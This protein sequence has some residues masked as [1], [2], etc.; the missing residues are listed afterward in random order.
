MGYGALHRHIFILAFTACCSLYIHCAEAQLYQKIELLKR[1]DGLSDDRVTCVYKDRTGYLWI[2]TEGGLNRYDGHSFTIFKP[3]AGNSISNEVINAITEDAS[4]KIWVAT[5]N[6]LNSYTPQ[7]KRWTAYLANGKN[8]SKTLP[9]PIVWSCFVDKD[10]RIWITTDRHGPSVLAADRS[11]FTHYPWQQFVNAAKPALKGQYFTAVKMIPAGDIIYLGS[12]IGLFTNNKLNGQFKWLGEANGNDILDMQYNSGSQKLYM[13]TRS[14]EVFFYNVATNHF[15]KLKPASLHFPSTHFWSVMDS[16]LRIGYTKGLLLA[17]VDTDELLLQQHQ[18]GI[19]ASLPSAGVQT[20]YSDNTGI[21]WIGTNDGLAKYDPHTQQANFLPLIKPEKNIA[22]NPMGAV[23]YDTTTDA[24]FVCSIETGEVFIISRGL[25]TIISRKYDAAGKRFN[26]CLAIRSDRQNGLWLLTANH[27]YKFNRQRLQFELFPTPNHENE[28]VFRDMAQDE[29]GNFW[30]AGF[31]SPLYF[32]DSKKKSFGVPGDTSIFR[33][34]SKV[35]SILYDSV[36]KFLWIGTFSNGL[37]RYD[38]R[39]KK[40]TVFAESVIAPHYAFF[41]LINNIYQDKNGR[42]WIATHAGGLFYYIPHQSFEHSFKQISMKDGLATNNMHSIT[43]NRSF[44]WAMSGKS[45]SVLESNTAKYLHELGEDKLLP[46]SSFISDEQNPHYIDFDHQR[47]ELLIA[48]GGGLMICK[49]I[50]AKSRADFPVIISAISVNNKP[51]LTGNS[52][53]TASIAF[54]YP[55]RELNIR[56][57]ALHYSASAA[58]RFRYKLTGYDDTWKTAV[59]TNELNFQNLPPG[60]Y[61]FQLGATDY[62]GNLSSSQAI[63]SFEVVPPF[64]K[65][66]LFYALVS[67]LAVLILVILFKQFRRKIQMEQKLNKFATSLYG[68]NTIDAVLREVAVACVEEFQFSGC[69]ILQWNPASKNYELLYSKGQTISVPQPDHIGRKSILQGTMLFELPILV[70]N[71]AIAQI[72]A[73]K[74]DSIWDNRLYKKTLQKAARV[75]SQKID[76]YIVE[77]GLRRKIARDLH[78]EIGSTL[79]SINIISKVA[80]QQAGANENATHQFKKIKENSHKMMDSMADMIWAINPGNDSFHKIILRMKE[81]ASEILEPAGIKYMFETDRELE[82][83]SFNSEQRKNIY[84]I[85]KEA[86]NNSVKYSGCTNI[87]IA[88]H[89]KE[90]TLNMAITDDGIGFMEPESHSGNGLANMRYRAGE[91][92]GNLSIRSSI[93]KGTSVILE[94]PIT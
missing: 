88:L 1:K 38:F 49:T 29:E 74:K 2:G 8:E 85:F 73:V 86:L 69:Q 6:G 75:C 15:K 45:I 79:T 90:E 5:M 43:G 24:Y 72:R 76:R 13:T 56:F 25:G 36:N 10:D 39:S 27:I 48:A 14:D 33:E 57:A 32:F 52:S 35:N 21:I 41:N 17:N 4:G 37:Y 92:G 53:H 64:W 78:D 30:F 20:V 93:N 59:N 18:P 19:P 11:G 87:H 68:Q 34:I 40:F 7:T 26:S 91:L 9:N 94:I 89:K 62:A 23:Y 22:S 51:V 50:V 82:S 46:F 70:D 12:T 3:H 31:H 54:H 55:M 81:F 80:M 84:L 83:I 71:M 77:D 66:N 60:K 42:I 63:F 58:V 61:T 16:R 44:I 65:S 28:T 47:N 67:M